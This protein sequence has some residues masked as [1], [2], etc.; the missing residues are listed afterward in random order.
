MLD[1]IIEKSMANAEIIMISGLLLAFSLHFLFSKRKFVTASVLLVLGLFVLG[2]LGGIL[3]WIFGLGGD[4]FLETNNIDFKSAYFWISTFISSVSEMRVVFDKTIFL[5]VAESILLS[6][7]LYLFS[8]W[9]PLILRGFVFVLIFCVLRV[10]YLG[11]AGFESGR[12]YVAHLKQQ[13]DQNPRG[14]EATRDVDLFVYIGESTSCL[15]MSLY[16]YPMPTTPRLDGLYRSEAGF[17]RFSNVLSTHT[18]T[19]PSL[20]R[21]L[22]ITSQQGG[23]HIQWGIGSV[24]KQSGLRPRL[25]SVQAFNGS[26][27]AFSRFVFNG[28]DL[29]LPA[30]DRYKGNLAI[31]KCKD[32]QLLEKALEGTGVVFFHSYAGHGP[33]LDNIDTTISSTVPKTSISFEGIYGSKIIEILNPNIS[34]NTAD[35]DRAIT[36]IDRN[37]SHAI[38]YIKSRNKPAVLIYFSDHGEAVYA[39]RSHDSSTFIHE[40]CTV[41]MVLFFN[42]AYRQKYPEIFIQYQKAALSRNTKLLDQISSTILDILRIHSTSQLDVPTLASSAKHPRPYIIER[43]TLSGTSKIDL[44]YDVKAGFSKARFIGGTPEPSYISVIREKFGK[45]N[46]ICYHRS[47]SFAKAL[48][49]ASVADGIEFDMVV[50]GDKLNLYHPPTTPT[51]FNINHI[52]SIAQARK[53]SLW[54]DAKNVSDPINCNKLVSYLEANHTR[55]GQI[56]VEFPSDATARLSDLQSCGRRLK[57]IGVRT[58]YYVPTHLLIPCA[59]NPTKNAST[60]KELNDHVQKAMASGIFTDLSFDFRGYQVMKRINGA[61]KFK[62]NTWTIKAQDFHRFPHQDFSFVIIDSSTDPN[63]Y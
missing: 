20:L 54:I 42:N 23:Q 55:V 49:A 31:S 11:Y 32:N 2:Y 61:D 56:L 40:M 34:K 5:V 17:L 33:Y 35:Y 4:S 36:Y 10:V 47:N 63:T 14:F 8:K 16:G 50:D 25:Y 53:N 13:F 9:R 41:P 18:H 29:N 62:W 3:A 22:A 19:S 24:L 48:R 46:I 21:A 37:V 6:T 27:A 30:E 43:E 39:K 52:F 12:S 45:E 51:G 60:F 38:E 44:D 15:N 57:S 1:K 59:E 26:F 7:L 58:S 28:I